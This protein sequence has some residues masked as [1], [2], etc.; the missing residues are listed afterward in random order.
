MIQILKIIYSAYLL[1][2]Y[3]HKIMYIRYT[4]MNSIAS[5]PSINSNSDNLDVYKN[6]IWVFKSIDYL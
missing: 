1:N 4:K 2:V 6:K 5:L 3:L